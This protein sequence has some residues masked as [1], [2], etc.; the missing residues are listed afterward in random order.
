MFKSDTEP[1]ITAFRNRVAVMCKAEVATGDAVKGDPES[2]GFVGNTVV[3][4]RGIIR[5]IKCHI[6][7]QHAMRTQRR[8]ANP[9]VVV[10]THKQHPVQACQENFQKIW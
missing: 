7:K 3:L 2:N 1:A 6:A 10:G 8:R 5:S 9:A 4:L